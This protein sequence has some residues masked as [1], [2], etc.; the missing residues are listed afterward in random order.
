M[1]KKEQETRKVAEGFFNV[2][3]EKKNEKVQ[4]QYRKLIESLYK[5]KGLVS[6]GSKLPIADA[7][8]RACGTAQ[9]GADL[10]APEKPVYVHIV[11]PE[12]GC[13][14][15]KNIDTSKAE[16]Y[17]GV[18][19]VYT[20]KDIPGINEI[21]AMIP[22]HPM[23]SI[24]TV[25]YYG[26]SIALVAAEDPLTAEEAADLVTAEYEPLPGIYSPYDAMK[27]E[28]PKV[29]P[30]HEN[31][32]PMGHFEVK[33]GDVDKVF[34]R[35]D[36][37]VVEH[38]YSTQFQEHAYL[39]PE[40]TLA[41]PEKDGSMTVM[42]GLQFPFGVQMTVAK[43]LGLPSEK[44]KVIQV[45]TGGSFGGRDST[46]PQAKA[47]LVAY[48]TKR[49]A[50]LVYTREE[51]MYEGIARHPFYLKY[52]TA[53]TKDGKLVA[54]DAKVAADTGAHEAYGC[55]VMWRGMAHFAGPYVIP[56]ARLDIKQYYTNNTIAGAFRGFGNPQVHF[57]AESQMDELAARLGMDPI[58]FR[59]KN[60]LHNGSTTVTG[61]VFD[62]S[63]GMDDCAK[64]AMELSRWKEK[65]A[66]YSKMKGVKRK[67]I[68]VAF[69]YHG[70]STLSEPGEGPDVARA[71]IIVNKDGTVIYRTGIIEMGQGSP[72]AHSLI[73]AEM[74]GIPAT[75]IKV[76]R[77]DSSTHP[78]AGLTVASRGTYMGGNAALVTSKL[79]ADR[80]KKKAA[81]VL[82]CKAEDVEMKNGKVWV[83][84]QPSKKMS[85]KELAARCHKDKVDLNVTE[86]YIIPR[87]FWDNKV[88][89]GDTYHAFTYSATV[90]EVEVDMET[91]QVRVLNVTPVY[92]PGRVINL[93]TAEGQV[94]G[95]VVQGTGYA[96][97]EEL[98]HKEGYVQNPNLADYYIP[99]S[100]DSP[101]IVPTFV[102]H[103]FKRG[104]FGAKGFAESPIV[105]TGVSIANAIYHASGARVRSL[106]VTS[107]KVYMALKKS[108]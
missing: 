55:G 27:P 69:M 95:G 14:R 25:W 57:A 39:D 77:F 48:K 99:T 92:D 54:V 71:T 108:V 73:V 1:V 5:K 101:E 18:V 40:A 32:V 28:A 97:M 45:A 79:V 81:E 30:P 52:K 19:G 60:I 86:A 80:M 70:T 7:I 85:F 26:E 89:Q 46:G 47:A 44:V 98:M 65:R 94:E 84:G 56:N 106:P 87:I 33:R 51:S 91:G 2:E 4:A 20:A 3:A 105:G 6:V 64:K 100:M 58:E 16:K 78:E 9:Y 61:Q 107:E 102:E 21:G 66:R 72:T 22:D 42:T 43:I 15:I 34:S 74:L 53:A 103:P 93:L 8:P 50:I 24:D 23:L 49:P 17:P 38:E 41:I 63:V 11:R 90:S 76:E 67:G 29:H 75:T 13:A 36:L 68:G 62:H 31:S 83:K 59:L 10:V 37:V 96:I 35:K 88:G 104:P 82:K 12:M